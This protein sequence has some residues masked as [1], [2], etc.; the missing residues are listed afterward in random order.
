MAKQVFTTVTTPSNLTV[1]M[2]ELTGKD[3]FAAMSY[4]KGDNGLLI[5]SL[6]MS[7]CTID[8]KAVTSQELDDMDIRDVSYLGEVI[9]LLLSKPEY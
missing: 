5:K 1:K 6:L 9:G 7:S 4:A 8:G 3:F 2:H